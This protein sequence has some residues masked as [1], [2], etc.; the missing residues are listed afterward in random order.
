[1]RSSPD[2]KLAYRD[3]SGDRAARPFFG[4]GRFTRGVCELRSK[5]N[6]RS[7]SLRSSHV[8]NAAYRDMSAVVLWTD[9]HWVCGIHGSTSVVRSRFQI[10]S[11]P[12]LL[13]GPLTSPTTLPSARRPMISA[14]SPSFNGTFQSFRSLSNAVIVQRVFA[15][16]CTTSVDVH[17]FGRSSC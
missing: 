7:S 1:M 10:T 13:S 3:P 15:K 8:A 14:V 5:T 6:Q 17:S 2:S 9:P 11:L 16:T 4:N 12:A